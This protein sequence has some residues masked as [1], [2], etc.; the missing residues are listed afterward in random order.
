MSPGECTLKIRPTHYLKQDRP[1]SVSP[2]ECT[3][4]TRPTH[5]L[6]QGYITRRVC[7]RNK[8]NSPAETRKATF[9]V[10]RRVQIETMSTHKLK[11]DR[12]QSVSPE[13]CTLKTRPTHILKQDYITK[14]VHIKNQVNSPSERKQATFCVTRICT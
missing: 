3:L 6:K 4:K 1:Q 8:A 9:C 5:I 7:I 12:P 11:Q 13:E 10:I 2:E 14:R